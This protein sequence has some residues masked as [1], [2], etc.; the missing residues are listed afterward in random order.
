MIEHELDKLDMK[1]A[2]LVREWV[3]TVDT[4]TGGVNAVCDALGARLPLSQ[5]PYDNCLFVREAGY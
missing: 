1:P 3:V 4:P 5:G 2:N